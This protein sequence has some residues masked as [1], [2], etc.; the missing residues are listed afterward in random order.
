AI[1]V[2][3]RIAGAQ[4]PAWASVDEL[5]AQMTP[6]IKP[7]IVPDQ[8][9]QE[10]RQQHQG[11]VQNTVLGRDGAQ[12]NGDFP[13]YNATDCHG[14]VAVVVDQRLEVGNHV[15]TGCAV[16]PL[17]GKYPGQPLADGMNFFDADL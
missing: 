2:V 11:K 6:Q 7:D 15:V 8:G 14:D 4:P 12:Q 1:Q 5:L 13:F 9:A 16:R 17:F 3:A 10:S